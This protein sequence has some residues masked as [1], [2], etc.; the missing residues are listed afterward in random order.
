MKGSDQ[1]ILA[2]SPVETVF[3]GKTYIWKQQSRQEQREI[4][5]DIAKIVELLSKAESFNEAEMILYAMEVYNSIVGFCEKHN[6]D[7]LSDADAV[8][9]YFRATGSRAL[10]ELI[11]NVFTP[12]YKAWLEPYIVGDEGARKKPKAKKSAKPKSTNS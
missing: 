2:G 1:H 9:E 8:E 4:R 12:V 7:M 5:V 11:D 3:N 6:E 10:S